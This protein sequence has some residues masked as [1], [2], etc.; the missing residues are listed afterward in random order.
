MAQVL[1]FNGFYTGNDPK[2]SSR[3]CVNFMPVR[4]DAGSLS[5]YTLES[6]QGILTSQPY[7]FGRNPNGIFSD[8]I[9]WGNK[10]AGLTGGKVL[11][12][13][14]AGILVA[15]NG[16]NV[17][18]FNLPDASIFSY[19]VRF[20]KGSTSILINTR[21]TESTQYGWVYDGSTPPSSVNYTTQLGLSG[22]ENIAD[23]AYFGDR[24]LIM[25]EAAGGS[26]HTGRVYYSAIGDPSS[27][28][29]LDFIRTLEQNSKNTGMHVLSGRL[30]LF[31]DD[32]YSVWTVTPSVNSPFL[33]QR[34]SRGSIGLLDPMG[35][36]ESGGA[37]YFIG[38]DGAKLGFYAMSGGAPQK[39]S[40]S[41]IDDI[42]NSNVSKAS[43]RCFD[44]MDGGR[45]FVAFSIGEY[46]MC[47]DLESGEYHRRSTGGGRWEVVGSG[48]NEINDNQQVLIGS[49]T[50]L[51]N[52]TTYTVNAGIT[53]ELVGT[54]FGSVV[55]RKLV[56]SPFN[57]DGVSNV[58]QELSFQTSIDY[59]SLS[60]A[61]LP[62]L[63][64]S[65]SNDF[66]KSY[67]VQRLSAFDAEGENTKLLRFMSIGFFRQAFVFKLETSNIY[68]HK[69][70][71]MLARLKKGFRQI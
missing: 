13:A 20:A 65:I 54:E 44:F 2:N 63:G 61:V 36:C 10:F 9:T 34:G 67:G 3:E 17:E 37:L 51:V 5:E 26:I 14:R 71:K 30:Y 1:P 45:K 25:S 32:D 38:R 42:L 21:S 69:I 58:V 57:S 70:L 43:I 48:Y 31:S 47:L 35:K 62:D 49:T 50:A 19:D 16:N 60:P 41:A 6:T 55:N 40:T 66:G 23:V 46:T 4:H 8:V 68:P 11:F 53:D 18:G 22:N 39:V 29:S 27:F 24:Y 12:V 7:D 28:S 59:S 64:L 56:T 33:P 15:T 52:A